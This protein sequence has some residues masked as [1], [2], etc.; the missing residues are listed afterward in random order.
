[1]TDQTCAS[2]SIYAFI[3]VIGC[4]FLATVCVMKERAVE[5]RFQKIDA[6]RGGG[7]FV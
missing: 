3:A 6:K 1:L 7:G 5:I 2:R 4:L